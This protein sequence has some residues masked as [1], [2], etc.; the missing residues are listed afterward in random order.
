MSRQMYNRARQSRAHRPDP[1]LFTPEAPAPD[2]RSVARINFKNGTS[3]LGKCDR[4]R[5]EDEQ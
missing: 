5:E 4:C 1:S 2:W 3:R